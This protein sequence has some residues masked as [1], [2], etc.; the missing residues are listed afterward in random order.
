MKIENAGSYDYWFNNLKVKKHDLEKGYCF[1]FYV[2]KQKEIITDM[3]KELLAYRRKNNIFEVG[4]LVVLP[5]SYSV[6][7][8]HKIERI[9][10]L[11]PHANN[12]ELTYFLDN[13]LGC[14][15]FQIRHATD[16]EIEQGYRDE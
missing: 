15:L 2:D 11:A 8:V 1:S 12:L 6:D 3:E 10:N 14:W 13:S 9:E 4:D 16:K 7:T 5:K